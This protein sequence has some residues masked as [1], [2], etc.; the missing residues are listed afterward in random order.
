MAFA[1]DEID[2]LKALCP[3]V[4]AGEEGNVTYFLLPELAL[5]EGCSPARVD[6]LLCP[7]PRDGY[8]FRL[9]F[10]Q[11][12]SSKKAL[13]WHVSGIRILERNWHAFSWKSNRT[14]LRL[15]QMVA[16]QLAALR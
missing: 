12:V 15:A 5:P 2:E 10:A 1:Q 8:E 4:S 13:N 6:A 9:Y 7:V 11:S 16:L 3:G 14:G